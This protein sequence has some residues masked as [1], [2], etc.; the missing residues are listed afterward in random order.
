MSTDYSNGDCES[1]H[2]PLLHTGRSR[3]NSTSQVAIV[4]ANVCPIESLDYESV[5]FFS[6][7][8]FH[9]FFEILEKFFI[10]F[11]GFCLLGMNLCSILRL[12]FW[13]MQDYRERV[14]QAG[15]E[16]P[17]E[18]SD[19]PVRIHEVGFVFVDWCDCWRGWILP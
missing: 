13:G 15:L 10:F 2:Q 19:T 12:L 7:F 1:L 14:L 17:T 18:D 11:M 9:L 6:C 8:F 16:E 3:I 4:G 5:F